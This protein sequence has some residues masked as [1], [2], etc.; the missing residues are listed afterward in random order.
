[1]I[2]ISAKDTDGGG[3]GI[4]CRNLKFLHW[5]EYAKVESDHQCQ[6]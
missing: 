2:A 6:S 5:R 1:M 3:G 4:S